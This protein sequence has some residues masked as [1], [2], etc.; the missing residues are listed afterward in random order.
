M[1]TPEHVRLI[2]Y[3]KPGCHLCDDAKADVE[4]LRR[5]GLEVTVEER[6]ITTNPEW[7]ER[8]RFTIPVAEVNGQTLEAPFNDHGLELLLRRAG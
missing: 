8:F 6:D 7:F 2:L 4:R 3:S 5:R 1:A